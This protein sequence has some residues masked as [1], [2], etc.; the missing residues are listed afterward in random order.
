MHTCP[1]CGPIVALPLATR[2]G[3]QVI[4]PKCRGI[5][6]VHASGGGYEIEWIGTVDFTWIPQPDVDTISDV[7]ANAP[8]VLRL[9]STSIDLLAT[10][11]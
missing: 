3:D 4:C 7:I 5:Y 8:R 11:V 1:D 2:D 6:N 10:A 9:P